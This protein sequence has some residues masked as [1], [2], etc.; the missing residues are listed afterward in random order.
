MTIAA[1]TALA[2]ASPQKRASA[3]DTYVARERVIAFN[4]ALGN[5]GG[6]N[7]T[8]VPAADPGMV[9]A[10]PSNNFSN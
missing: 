9:A 8:R 1:L 7:H 4:H 6:T 2:S 3:L 5:I 10:S